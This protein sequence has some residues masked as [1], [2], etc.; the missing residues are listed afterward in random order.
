M[1][2]GRD[3]GATEKTEL[4][5]NESTVKSSVEDLEARKAVNNDLAV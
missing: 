2:R 3:E 4:R 5:V 1:R